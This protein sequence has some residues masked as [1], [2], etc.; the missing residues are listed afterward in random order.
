LNKEQIINLLKQ[1]VVEKKEPLELILVGALALPFYGVEFRA[2]YDL[3]AEVET[4]NIEELYFFLKEK[5]FESDLSENIAGWS[6][7]TLPSG[8]QKRSKIVYKDN[9]LTIKILSPEDFIIMKLR[10][11][12]NQDIQDALAVAKKQSVEIEKL[13]E[14]YEKVLK[15]SI[16]DTALFNFKKIYSV[17]INLLRQV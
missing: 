16:K 9:F 17:F 13:N 5:G 4:G 7:I 2:T 8:Y 11:G 1:F 14:L 3:D 10:R 6:V 12:T 15:E